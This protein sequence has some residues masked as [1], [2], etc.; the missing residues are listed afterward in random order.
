MAAGRAAAAGHPFFTTMS[1]STCGR[2]TAGVDPLVER[3]DLPAD[4]DERIR[5]SLEQR[6]DRVAHDA[7]ALVLEAADLDQILVEAAQR[8]E[9]AERRGQ[10]VDGRDEHP[11]LRERGRGDR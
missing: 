2:V 3:L 4:H 7:V 8:A 10:A 9:L 1:P 11:A 6:R 5:R